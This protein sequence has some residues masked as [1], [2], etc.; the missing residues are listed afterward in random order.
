MQLLPQWI[1][2]KSPQNYSQISLVVI[3]MPSATHSERS[4]PANLGS[5]CF[6]HIPGAG[7]ES[8]SRSGLPQQLSD[9]VVLAAK[10]YLGL[11]HSAVPFIFTADKSVESSFY[12]N[13]DNFVDWPAYPSRVF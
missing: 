3:R 11:E 8:R 13:R 1:A 6:L 9:H 7:S 4:F 10:L 5:G 2:V 12:Q